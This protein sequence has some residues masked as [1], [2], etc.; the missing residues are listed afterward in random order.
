MRAKLRVI[1]SPVSQVVFHVTAPWYG[2]PPMAGTRLLYLAY[3]TRAD[4][5]FAVTKLQKHVYVQGLLD[6]EALY[7]LL[8]HIKERPVLAIKFY[9]KCLVK[10]P[11]HDLCKTNSIPHAASTLLTVASW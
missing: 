7:W 2:A 8:G 11:S 6:Y 5:L 1:F 10:H 4:I 9:P 3:N